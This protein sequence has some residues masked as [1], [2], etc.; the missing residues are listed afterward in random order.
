MDAIVQ[1]LGAFPPTVHPMIV[2]FPI[3]LLYVAAFFALASEV[4]RL[5]QLGVAVRPM[6]GLAA[7]FAIVAVVT[8]SV[9]AHRLIGL[10]PSEAS[11]VARHERMGELT[12]VATLLTF[13]LA[14]APSRG[15]RTG[16]LPPVALAALL[17]S[18]GLVSYTGFLGGSLV[19]DK[20]VGVAHSAPVSAGPAAS[21]TRS[22]ARGTT[23]GAGVG[24]SLV[25]EGRSLWA[26]SCSG[27][28]GDPSAMGAPFVAE[29]GEGRLIAFLAANMPPGQP[30]TPTEAK[31]IVKFLESQP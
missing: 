23:G 15:S 30:V 4:P 29:V 1:R 20:G 2:H 21:R 27:C 9:A 31:A 8:G 22:P 18:T 12:A 24:E 25:S 3:A 11:L 14:V 7:L 19:Y 13:V 17:V 10:T 16:R 6:L 5:A 26:S 28:H